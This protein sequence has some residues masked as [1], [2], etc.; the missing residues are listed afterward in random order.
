MR[1]NVCRRCR[2]WEQST[3]DVRAG[4]CHGSRPEPL[5][6]PQQDGSVQLSRMF[7][8]TMATDWCAQWGAR[9][10]R[11]DDEMP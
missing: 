7:P 6:I 9:S 11:G 10:R 8:V 4:E 3:Q 2:Y 1:E 5:A